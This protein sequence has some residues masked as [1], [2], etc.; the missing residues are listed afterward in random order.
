M[1]TVAAALG[2]APELLDDASRVRS[3][4]V[5]AVRAEPAEPAPG[6]AV[7]LRALVASPD[8]TVG[9]P[10]LRWAF[11]TARRALATPGPVYPACLEES[12]PAL[13]PVGTGAS[14]GGALPTDACRL[15]GAE[16]PDDRQGAGG[17]P[18]DPDVTGGFYLPVQA[19]LTGSAP[20]VFQARIGCRPGGL[21]QVEAAELTRRSR[22][23][24]NPSVASLRA[25]VGGRTIAVE[26]G[27]TVAVTPGAT[28]RFVLGWA[29]CPASARCGDGVCG[30]DE[31]RAGCA[32]DCTTPRGCTG[33]EGYARFDPATRSVVTTREVLR[34]S[35]FATEGSFATP[36]TGSEATEQSAN[37]WTA[38]A[39]AGTARGWVVLRDDR[40]GADWR[41]F[42]VR[43]GE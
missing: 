18:V 39:T 28:V 36:R 9:E 32:E 30:E 11:C 22:R 29:E 27:A 5:L 15:F 2:C 23:N 24:E 14:A 21:S 13:V 7:T 41:T 31:T 26:E 38:P 12:D 34:A 42:R 3:T 20:T 4:R 19:R 25:I 33:A 37:E 35:W 17:R 8:G 10:S 1:V 6:E 43:V 16:P 40:G